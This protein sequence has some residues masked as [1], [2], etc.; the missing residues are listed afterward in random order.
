MNNQW[1]KSITKA[2]VCLGMT[3]I[4]LL[5]LIPELSHS[6]ILGKP[7]GAADGQL[8]IVDGNFL[9][10]GGATSGYNHFHIY[11]N[12][13]GQS[14]DSFW[15]NTFCIEKDH[16]AASGSEYIY[17]YNAASIGDPGYSSFISTVLGINGVDMTAAQWAMLRNCIMYV[18]V[19]RD[20]R[21]QYVLW[22]GLG[23]FLPT[24][25]SR[26]GSFGDPWQDAWL[27]KYFGAEASPN[28]MGLGSIAAGRTIDIG[29]TAD[30]TI[31]YPTGFNPAGTTLTAAT[32]RI[33]PFSLRWTPGSD[34]ALAQLNCGPNKTTPP[35]FNLGA[36]NSS[37][38]FYKNSTTATPTASVRLGDEFYIE[39]NDNA[40]SGDTTNIKVSS[41]RELITKV[42]ADQF[43]LNPVA[44][45]QANVETETAR[46]EFNF[47]V[48]TP[49]HSDPTP[50]GGGEEYTRPEIEK[51][52]AVDNHSD[53]TSDFED[54]L[55]V[56]PGTDVFH[57]M[58]VTSK[59]PNGTILTFQNTDYDLYP[60][61]LQNHSIAGASNANVPGTTALVYN[62]AEFKAAID[63]NKNIKL[64]AD[65][66]LPNGWLPSANVYSGIFDGNNYKLI[67]GS[68]MT[69][70]VFGETLN[71][72]FYRV[73][74]V[75]FTMTRAEGS[76][77]RFTNNN[78]SFGALVDLFIGDN[79]KMLD[80]Y[81]QGK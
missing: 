24:K 60:S 43:F 2:C 18:N 56:Y 74:F 38:R 54:I 27:T 29:A 34:A 23:H 8:T 41:V 47:I 65:I 49:T 7:T 44:Q 61:V 35:L 63:A 11:G 64:M 48:A 3:L 1:I 16:S 53:D 13:T 30:V 58:T 62:A 37:V 70:S 76:G 68:D 51:Q 50:P 71:A 57:K 26:A 36:D 67:G 33:G 80:C 32:G 77:T 10:S 69:H 72:V 5:Q 45:N 14:P 52:V 22:S 40:K 46:P 66:V 79:S 6:V 15:Q 4:L 21:G 31:N 12:E 73:Q 39:W 20:A 28:F 78:E 75:D 59:D 42:V 17:Y 25:Y 9:F 81:V 19:N 55:E